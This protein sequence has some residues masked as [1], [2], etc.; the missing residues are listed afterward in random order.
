[1]KKTPP[2]RC[3]GRPGGLFAEVVG[4]SAVPAA[5]GL[6]HTRMRAYGPKTSPALWQ[7]TPEAVIGTI[8]RSRRLTSLRLSSDKSV[9]FASVCLLLGKTP[10]S[11]ARVKVAARQE[12]SHRRRTL[13]YS[14]RCLPFASR[15][16][17]GRLST[18]LGPTK[19]GKGFY[20]PERTVMAYCKFC[21]LEVGW[22]LTKKKH[23]IPRD[24][25]NRDHR[26]TCAAFKNGHRN[27]VR[28]KNHENMVR[29]FLNGKGQKYRP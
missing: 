15:Y 11:C 25:D 14:G 17:M 8:Y 9:S 22:D 2:V 29:S 26:E 10:V 3:T 4:E 7:Q 21:G 20:L 13:S 5:T 16:E 1:M 24:R 12:S 6:D 19:R 18:F 27:Q 28:D 23:P